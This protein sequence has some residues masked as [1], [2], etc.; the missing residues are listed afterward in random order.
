MYTR[1][2]CGIGGHGHSHAWNV[3]KTRYVISTYIACLLFHPLDEAES[4]G[5]ENSYTRTTIASFPVL[6]SAYGTGLYWSTKELKSR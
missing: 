3:N 2:H 5:S 1:T 6:H 4:N